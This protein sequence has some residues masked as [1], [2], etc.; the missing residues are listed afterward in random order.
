MEEVNPESWLVGVYKLFQYAGGFT[1]RGRPVRAL[2]QLSEEGG[3]RHVFAY[4]TP[5]DPPVSIQTVKSNIIAWY[6][7]DQFLSMVD[8]LRN[9]KPIYV[10]FLDTAETRHLSVATS[11]EPVGEEES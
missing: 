2:I 6:A 7:C 5:E 4:F 10:H 9:E 11:E 8:M 3:D 1:F